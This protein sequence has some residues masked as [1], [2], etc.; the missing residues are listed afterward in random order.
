M[1][2]AFLHMTMGLS[3]R[4]SEV[5]VDQLATSLSLSHEVLVIQSG[6]VSQ[7]KYLVKRVYPLSEAPI[8][9]PKN[10]FQKLLFRM[11]LDQNSGD[12]AEFTSAAIKELDS[13]APDI[14]VAVNGPVQLA[15]LQGLASQAK[16]VVFGHAGIG[17]HDAASLAR[18]P[19][20]FIALT[21]VAATW[22]TKKASRQSKVVYIPNPI[23][24][25]RYLGQLPAKTG[26]DKPIVMTVGAL[27]SYKNIL[28]VVTAIKLTAAS[29][30]L[31]GDGEQSGELSKMFSLLG[32]SFLWIKHLAPSDLGRYYR[33]ADVFCLVPDSQE[34]FGMVYL[35]AMAAGLPIVASD[36]SIRRDLVGEQGI[37]VDPHDPASIAS[38]INQAIQ[39]D[40]IDY[41]AR[42][43][44]YDL[45]KVVAKIEKEFHDLIS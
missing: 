25:S 23:D 37:Y 1:K 4:G 20:L 7:K 17:H 10:I 12:V 38:G 39:L 44:D 29:Y 40:R 45:A 34:S 26:L 8:P 19:D 9:A 13:F 2:I 3:D 15:L 31:I 42:L 35:E 28:Q 43:V 21:N 33:A 24:L 14:I 41:S 36:D 27:S 30:L 5:V 18:H 32:N 6:A 16:I 11:N 22:A